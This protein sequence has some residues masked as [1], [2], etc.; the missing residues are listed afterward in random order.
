MQYLAHSKCSINSDSWYYYY[1]YCPDFII[2][3]L[4]VYPMFEN[5]KIFQQ[6]E[7]LVLT[8]ITQPSCAW[9]WQAMFNI[10]RRQSEVAAKPESLCFDFI[11]NVGSLGWRCQW[12]G[13]HPRISGFSV[14]PENFNAMGCWASTE[15]AVW[16]DSSLLWGLKS[17]WWYYCLPYF[18]IVFIKIS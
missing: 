15:R 13:H 7:I 17:I 9:W 6:S 10:R 5:I 16:G 12:Q 2:P 1:Y 3:Q 18:S 4:W 8:F 14:R 11:L